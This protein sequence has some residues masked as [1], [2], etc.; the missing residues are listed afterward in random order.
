MSEPIRIDATEARLLGVLVEK[1]LTTPEQYPLSINAVVNGA[2]QK[3][4]RFPVV[5]LD[6]EEAFDG[7]E[8][9]IA[10]ELVR[11]VWPGNSRVDKYCHNATA[12]LQLRVAEVAVLAEL[13]LRG[14]QT[15]GELRARAQRMAPLPTLEDLQG[16]LDQLIER[17]FVAYRPPSPGSR[18]ALYEQLL[19]PDAHPA[20]P[21]RSAPERATAPG[22]DRP[23][24]AD[25]GLAAR[26]TALEES[27]AQL[28]A[29]LQRLAAQLGAALDE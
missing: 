24:A 8:H 17:G 13:L 27:V 16:V 4:N 20:G 15:S 14:P 11:R 26:V 21:E 5:H 9:L 7:L 18:A 6:E 10:K 25:P 22:G 23:A 12:R 2:N 28:T 29:R 19:S 1:A 3:S